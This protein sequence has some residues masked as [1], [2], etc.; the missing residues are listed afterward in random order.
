MTMFFLC[1]KIFFTRILDV[2]LGTTRT[3]FTVKGKTLIAATI[4]FVEL[5]IWFMVAREALQTNETSVFVAIALAGGF[6]TG[7]AIGSLI[8]K[9]FIKGTIS[10]QII[11]DKDS[12][13]TDLRNDGYALSVM[14]IKGKDTE[15]DKYMILMEI[16]N[17]SFNVLKSKISKYDRRAFVIVNETKYVQNGLIK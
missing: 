14:D 3:I 17:S 6:S 7:T 9:K 13:I 10:V 11:T 1:L 8:A 4:G 16:K 2:S 5:F 12:L 15:V